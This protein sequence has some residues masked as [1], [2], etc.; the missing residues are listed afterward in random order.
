MVLSFALW[1]GLVGL[2]Y[3]LIRWGNEG[4]LDGQWKA[5]LFILGMD[6]YA[7]GMMLAIV[8]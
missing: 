8:R 1:A 7:F 6:V 3:C 4:K 2:F 5:P